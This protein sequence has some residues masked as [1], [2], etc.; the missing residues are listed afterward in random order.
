MQKNSRQLLD[1]NIFKDKILS[2][3]T[4]KAIENVISSDKRYEIILDFYSTK[5]QKSEIIK[6]LNMSKQGY[7]NLEIALIDKLIV[8]SKELKELELMKFCI[9][10]LTS[11]IRHNWIN[12][13]ATLIKAKHQKITIIRKNNRVVAST[14]L[15]RQLGCSTQISDILNEADVP[16]DLKIIAKATN[17]NIEELKIAIDVIAP[18]SF[19]IYDN[20]VMTNKQNSKLGGFITSFLKLYPLASF[21]DIEEAAKK[22]IKQ[23]PKKPI[24]IEYIKRVSRITLR[25]GKYLTVLANEKRKNTENNDVEKYADKIIKICVD[26]SKQKNIC[27]VNARGLAYIVSITMNYKIDPLILKDI[28]IKSGEFVSSGNT[29]LA[30]KSKSDCKNEKLKTMIEK[31]YTNNRTITPKELSEALLKHGRMVHPQNSS[32]ILKKIRQNI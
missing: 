27:S 6:K 11:H 7:Y 19:I 28:L 10:D 29:I 26:F 13:I 22:C 15:F 18:A 12:F 5:K 23:I 32:S 4:L 14:Y 30:H 3:K 25:D 8:A 31:I 2:T 21:T 1:Y 9:Y 20:Y 24:T 17:C 16:F